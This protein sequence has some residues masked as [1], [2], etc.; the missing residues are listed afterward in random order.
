MWTSSR[1]RPIA[2]IATIPIRASPRSPSATALE[3]DLLRRD[4]TINAMARDPLTGEIIDPYGG[5]DDL[6]RG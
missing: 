2:A 1:S 4:F 6:E 5:R 3:D